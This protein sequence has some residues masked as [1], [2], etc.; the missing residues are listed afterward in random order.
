MEILQVASN[1]IYAATQ[2]FVPN[3]VVCAPDVLPVLRF[4]PAFNAA[5]VSQM[6]GPFIA[7]DIDNL[8]VVVSPALD[9]GRFLVGLNGA[10]LMSSVAVF[11]TY[12][13]LVPTQLLQFADGLTE[14]GFSSMYDIKVLNPDLIVAGSVT[15]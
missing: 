2:K 14:Q 1:K 4:I 15:A 12:M 6:A 8:K 3:Y 10:D 11:G 5:Q 9:T 13:P 7:G